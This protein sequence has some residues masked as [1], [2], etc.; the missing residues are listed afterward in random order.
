MRR[1]HM[2]ECSTHIRLHPDATHVSCTSYAAVTCIRRKSSRTRTSIRRRACTC[3]RSSPPSARSWCSDI[4]A[5]AAA[6]R[7]CSVASAMRC[8]REAKQKVSHRP[9][10]SLHVRVVVCALLEDMLFAKHKNAKLFA[11]YRQPATHFTPTF[12]YCLLWKTFGQMRSAPC[13]YARSSHI[14]L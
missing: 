2:M 5:S 7:R 4:R 12:A 9:V 10:W 11:H 3:R 1:A 13:E 8:R 6:A 14:L